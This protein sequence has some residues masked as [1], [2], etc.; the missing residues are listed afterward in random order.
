[1]ITRATNGARTRDTAQAVTSRF[2][3][4]LIT[5]QQGFAKSLQRSPRHINA[6]R[7]SKPAV[8]PKYHLPEG[9]VD[10]NA[11]SVAFAPTGR[12]AEAASY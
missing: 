8:L 9:S 5:G 12:V 11:L 2:E 4:H 6:T 10:I 1:M 3:H 7:M